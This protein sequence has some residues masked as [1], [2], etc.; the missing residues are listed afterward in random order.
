VLLLVGGP[1]GAGKSTVSAAWCRTRQRAVR[2]DLDEIRDLV[3]AGRVDPQALTPLQAQQY[4]TSVKACAALARVFL[5]D[6]YDVAIE[7][8]FEPDD[9]TRRWQ[10]LLAGLPWHLVVLRPSLPV[11]LARSRSRSKRVLEEHT[12]NQYAA[13]GRWSGD[14]QLDTSELSVART[15]E[16]I[17]DRLRAMDPTMQHRLA[18]T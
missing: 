15:V 5:A 3:V 11:T 10:P 9:F 6:G 16:I 13:T 1:A 17:N 4:H 12:T 18:D 14:V 2:V 8:V 7:T